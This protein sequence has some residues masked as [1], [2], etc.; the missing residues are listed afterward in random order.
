MINITIESE[1]VYNNLKLNE[2]L[3]IVEITILAHE[4]KYGGDYLKRVKVKCVAE[5]LD[6]KRYKKISHSAL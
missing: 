4:Q 2:S 6:K 1:Y 5:F 3:N